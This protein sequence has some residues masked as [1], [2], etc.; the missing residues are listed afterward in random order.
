MQTNNKKH[1]KTTYFVNIFMDN[2]FEFDI[3]AF[4]IIEAKL[5]QQQFASKIG[6]NRGTLSKIEAGHAKI[7]DGILIKIEQAYNID[8][9]KYKEAY[10]ESVAYKTKDWGGIMPIIEEDKD[11]EHSK[12]RQELVGLLKEQTQK[13]NET[14]A[15]LDRVRE[16]KEELFREM[17]KLRA[18]QVKDLIEVKEK[19]GK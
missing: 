4:R 3:K 1:H 14:A 6:I 16:E 9:T 7:T 8:L 18:D 5:K 2:S 19:L 11:A 17:L 12:E 10:K 13:L 15:K